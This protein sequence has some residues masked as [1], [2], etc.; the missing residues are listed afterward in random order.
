MV[1]DI[2]LHPIR[3]IGKHRSMSVTIAVT[4]GAMVIVSLLLASAGIFWATRE[5]DT[6]SVER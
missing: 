1:A 2:R 4:L 6:V 3:G 5:S